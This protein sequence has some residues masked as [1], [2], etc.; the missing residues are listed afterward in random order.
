MFVGPAITCRCGPSEFCAEPIRRTGPSGK[1]I[2]LALVN[3]H[4]QSYLANIG[5]RVGHDHRETI[6][7]RGKADIPGNADVYPQACDGAKAGLSVAPEIW[8]IAVYRTEPQS[9]QKKKSP[10]C[11]GI[12]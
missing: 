4:T 10:C 2:V 1:R 9:A 7:E 3:R 6:P 8:R 5:V 11:R 12:E